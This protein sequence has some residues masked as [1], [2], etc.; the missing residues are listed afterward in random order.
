MFG[1]FSIWNGTVSH[2]MSV[3]GISY[4][5]LKI[6]Y[7]HLHL[8][9]LSLHSLFIRKHWLFIVS[10][11]F[12]LNELSYIN[13]EKHYRSDWPRTGSSNG[14]AKQQSMNSH[15]GTTHVR[16]PHSRTR[17]GP[18]TGRTRSIFLLICDVFRTF[19]LFFS[20]PVFFFWEK[21]KFL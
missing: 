8:F 16:S 10:W 18:H 19:L 21:T 6:V 4:V 9:L 1:R 2:H 5:A 14:Q 13:L 20:W 11:F 7:T 15:Q 12:F 3:H 17:V